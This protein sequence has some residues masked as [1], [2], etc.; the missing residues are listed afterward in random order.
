MNETLDNSLFSYPFKLHCK[1][2][3]SLKKYFTQSI[4]TGFLK[5]KNK[6][7]IVYGEKNMLFIFIRNPIFVEKYQSVISDIKNI[8]KILE[9]NKKLTINSENNDE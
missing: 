6:N 5:Y 8:A 3:A 7:Y 4:K 1:D 9:S 2:I